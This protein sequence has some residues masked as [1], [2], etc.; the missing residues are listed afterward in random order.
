MNILCENNAFQNIE[1]CLDGKCTYHPVLGDNMYHQIED[2]LQFCIHI[3]FQDKIYIAGNVPVTVFYETRKLITRLVNYGITD[4]FHIELLGGEDSNGIEQAD[5]ILTN[6]VVEKLIGDGKQKGTIDGYLAE[7]LQQQ[8]DSLDLLWNFFPNLT[9]EQKEI[10]AQVT[11]AIQNNKTDLLKTY[12]ALATVRK[13]GGLLK[14]FS[15]K[16]VSEK[17]IS[18]HKNDWS[19]LMTLRLMV[20]FRNLLNKTLANQGK[21]KQMLAPSVIRGRT[22]V[23]E[24][25]IVYLID[26]VF[27]NEQFTFK[28]LVDN[29]IPEFGHIGSV[30]MPSITQY[31]INISDG[32]VERILEETAKLRDRFSPVRNCI[33]SKNEND[34]YQQWWN[35]LK[36]IANEVSSRIE[37][38]PKCSLI[39]VFENVTVVPMSTSNGLL[40][41]P[42]TQGAIPK[43][44]KLMKDWWMNTEACV[45]AFSGVIFSGK[46]KKNDDGNEEALIDY[47][48]RNSTQ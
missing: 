27:K 46:M 4:V 19:L 36:R 47:C 1:K 21:P 7:C 23:D 24:R 2:M 25:R 14:I 15:N 17:I 16:D 33:K 43:L 20:K 22:T 40:P 8:N 9:P 32:S 6:A 11:D 30:N 31:L 39:N 3:I 41:F 35:E 13:D 29:D 28:D 5:E 26:K 48:C 12:N 44:V 42:R 45:Q 18:A 34:I 10:V 38:L 37:G